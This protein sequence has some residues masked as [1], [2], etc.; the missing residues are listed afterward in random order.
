MTRLPW[1]L[2]FFAVFLWFS[3]TALVAG[4]DLPACSTTGPEPP[5]GVEPPKTVYDRRAIV[6]ET[7][8]AGVPAYDWRHGC[9]PTALGMVVGYWD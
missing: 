2:F 5:P 6:D 4:D 8:I 7:E 3:P 1:L 9:G